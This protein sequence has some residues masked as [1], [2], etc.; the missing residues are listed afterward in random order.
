MS[1]PLSH[2]VADD[3]ISEFQHPRHE[4]ARRAGTPA[5]FEY[6]GASSEMAASRVSATRLLGEQEHRPP[7]STQAP[8]RRWP[9]P[10]FPPLLLDSRHLILLARPTGSDKSSLLKLPH[11][12]VWASQTLRQRLAQVLDAFRRLNEQ[13]AVKQHWPIGHK[14]ALAQLAGAVNALEQPH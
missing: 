3:K 2:G 12:Q 4:T 5:V 11:Q 9:R 7:L 14:H 10:A 8:H 13:R 6:A 1:F